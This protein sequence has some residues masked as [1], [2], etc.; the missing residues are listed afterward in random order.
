MFAIVPVAGADCSQRTRLIG[1]SLF[2]GVF[3]S[4]T[5]RHFSADPLRTYE[6]RPNSHMRTY[7]KRLKYGTRLARVC[8]TQRETPSG[9]QRDSH[10][11]PPL[12]SSEAP[13]AVATPSPMPNRTNYLILSP[14]P[15][16]GVVLQG[17]HFQH[18]NAHSPMRKPVQR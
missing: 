3:Q 10:P 12:S 18:A 14:S 7:N 2:L 6:N 11:R 9:V 8:T 17:R 4:P 1:F 13:L 16:Q 5:L 15:S